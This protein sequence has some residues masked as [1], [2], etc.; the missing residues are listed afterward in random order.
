MKA[1]KYI[2][3]AIFILLSSNSFATDTN[4]GRLCI[5]ELPIAK[6][7]YG[8]ITNIEGGDDWGSAVLVHFRTGNSIIKIPLNKR[9]NANDTQGQSL[10][11]AL[12]L[13]FINF[14]PVTLRDHWSNNCDDFD[15]VILHPIER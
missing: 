13:A 12:N 5:D 11:N 6:M 9:Y 1:K 14:L 8:F 10:I 4:P 2:S 7:E 3:F 15:Q